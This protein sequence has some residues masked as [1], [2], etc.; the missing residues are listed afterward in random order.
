[1][2]KPVSASDKIKGL[3]ALLKLRMTSFIL[4]SVGLGFYYGKTSTSSLE[5]LGWALVGSLL[6]AMSCFSINQAI[7]KDLDKKMPRTMNRP[8]PTG[9]VTVTEAWLIGGGSF[10]LGMVVLG[11][12]VNSL[13]CFLGVSIVLSYCFFYTPWKQKSSINTLIGAIPGAIPPLIGWST[14][15]GSLGRGAF[16]L[17][18][19]LY[20][21]QL[22][23]FLAIAWLYREDYSKGNFHMWSV[24][25]PS[26]DS[27]F[28]QIIIQSFFLLFASLIPV[29]WGVAGYYYGAL[30]WVGGLFFIYKGFQLYKSKSDS[31][32]R[33]LFYYSLIYL[34][35]ILLALILDSK[36]SLL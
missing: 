22:P 31:S 2:S 29:L 24:V 23:H 21:W 1:M 33:G 15:Q 13:T 5:E 4:V 14:A 10:I 3:I 19:I 35:C 36:N 6:M 18:L 20:F 25:D 34:P 9:V 8:I 30:A 26:G 32:A 12:K 7:E 16:L 27:C 17:F 28:R 11:S